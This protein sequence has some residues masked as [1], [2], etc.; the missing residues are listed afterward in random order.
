[1]V[2]ALLSSFLGQRSMDSERFRLLLRQGPFELRL[3]ERMICAKIPFE[4]PFESSSKE[5]FEHLSRYLQG[6]NFKTDKIL[7]HGPFFQVHKNNSWEMG[8][9]LP[10]DLDFHHVPKPIHRFIKIEELPPCRVASLKHRGGDSITDIL[11]RGETLKRWLTKHE[12]SISSPVRL[13]RYHSSLPW[14]FFSHQE[15][16]FDVV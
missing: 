9:I 6:N 3:Y 13:A 14:S 4:P 1:M 12:L 8:I 16:L 5:A 15:V 11:E 2:T 7:N 10:K